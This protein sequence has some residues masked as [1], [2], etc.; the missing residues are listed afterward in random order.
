MESE[1]L[2]QESNS[3]DNNNPL[4]KDNQK[5]HKKRYWRGYQKKKKFSNPIKEEQSLD[6]KNIESTTDTTDA[7]TTK[8]SNE[9]TIQGKNRTKRHKRQRFSKNKVKTNEN[10]NAETNQPI[11][12]D[13]TKR[14][15]INTSYPIEDRVAIVEGNNL[16][17]FYVESHTRQQLKGNIYKGV[18]VSILPSVQAVFVDFGQSKNGF[19]QFREIMPSLYEDKITD[20][21]RPSIQSV[22]SK[23]QELLVQVDKDEHDNKGATLTTYISLAGRYVVMLPG[24]QKI[25]ISRKIENRQDRDKLK[26]IFNSLNLPKGMGFILRTACNDSIEKELNL[27]LK[28]L[29]KLWQTIKKDA[30]KI[31]GPALIYKEHD[32]ALKTVRDYLT[33]D[34]EEIITDTKESFTA[35][36]SFIKKI[37]PGR[38]FNVIYYKEQKPLFSQYDIETQIE[39]LNEPIVSLPSR[40]YLIINKTEALTAID[41]NS[42]KGKKEDNIEATAFNTNLE[43]VLEIARQIRLRDIGGLIVIDFIDMQSSKNKKVIEQK[44]SEALNLDRANTEI[45]PL[46]KFCILEM[47]RERIRPSFAENTT[48]KC[49]HCSGQ[50]FIKSDTASALKV[51]RELH[52]KLSIDNYSSITC[53]VSVEV[54]NIILNQMRQNITNLEKNFGVKIFIIADKTLSNSNSIFEASSI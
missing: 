48:T 11:S 26:E 4:K 7:N 6:S 49:L 37:I 17:D 19:L 28:Y 39:Q 45:A 34:T 31:K 25:G 33:T 13:T 35:I 44:M 22:I 21:G 9:N 27:D 14:I 50:G 36:K 2:K 30:E 52:S 8:L 10:A 38:S 20:K 15:L 12:K 47:T 16:I 43:A 46:S 23:G 5:P 42:G 1:A 32:L 54:A 53:K 51:L 3:S 41:V 24:Q 18:V 40:G 29:T